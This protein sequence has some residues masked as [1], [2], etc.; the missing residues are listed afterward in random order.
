MTY[1]ILER[2]D[3]ITVRYS[4][5]VR[6]H[7]NCHFLQDPAW[8]QVKALWKWRGIL[9]LDDDGRILGAMSVLLRPLPLGCH[10]AYAPRGPVCIRKD[11]RVMESLTAGLKALAKQFKCLLTYL[12]PDEPESNEAFRMLMKELGY[13]E[14]QS[15]DFSGVQPQSVFRLSLEDQTEESLLA[16]FA[17]KTRYNIR[18]AQKRGV[19]VE[20]YSGGKEISQEALKSF[21]RLMQ[22]TGERDHFLVRGST[23]FEQLLHAL[24][25]DAVLYLAYLEER[26]I[27]GSIAIFY[28]DK[29]WYLY[30]A[31]ANEQRGAMPNYLLQWTM[32]LEALKRECRIYDF[33]GVP[34][35]GRTDDPLYGLYRFKKGFSGEHMRFTGLF[36]NFHSPVLGRLF[37]WIQNKY[38]KIRK[39]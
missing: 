8:A 19:R 1:Q 10:V 3:P 33:R 18:L 29:A 11:A 24:K 31:S 7:S 26:P 12:D 6:E 27:A 32:I 21:D 15:D 30:G 39:R 23:Y 37:D 25:N 13:R 4:Q 20:Q 17:Q 38:R 9:A 14:R 5:F 34:G 36:T 28:G 22:T 16:S 2:T 35:T